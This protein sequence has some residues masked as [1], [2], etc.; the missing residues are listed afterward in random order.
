MEYEPKTDKEKIAYLMATD[1]RREN[2]IKALKG[3]VKALSDNVSGLASS[4][5]G[6]ALNGNKGLITFLD[7]VKNSVDEIKLSVS[8]F[9]K[10][11]TLVEADIKST[12]TWS[13][14]SGVFIIGFFL[15]IANYLK[16]LIQHK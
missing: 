8:N 14:A 4:I 12:K 10:R 16:D 9:D 6:S 1:S 5:T 15:I 3:D 7:D 2:H 11:I 13:K